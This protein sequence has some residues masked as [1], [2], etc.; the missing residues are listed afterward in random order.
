MCNWE[1]GAAPIPDKWWPVIQEAITAYVPPGPEDWFWPKVDIRGPDEC[2]PWKWHRRR[3]GYGGLRREGKSLTASRV[4]WEL[5][6]GPIPVD[7]LTGRELWILH[8]CDNPPCC[9]PAHLFV[10]T[11]ED[12]TMDAARKGR[13]GGKRKLQAEQVRK[14]R[15]LA[16]EG[17]SQKSLAQQFAVDQTTISAIILRRSWAQIE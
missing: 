3:H 6:N 13:A 10:G 15:A 2:W 1:K 17:R 11:H 8:R 7:P 16:A 14:I 9:N 4:A 5:A 12:N